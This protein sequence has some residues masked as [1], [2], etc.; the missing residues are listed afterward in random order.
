MN[1]SVDGD[2]VAVEIFPEAEWKAP[3]DEVVDED[4][5]FITTGRDKMLMHYF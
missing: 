2:I 4:G 1:R 5:E 3:D